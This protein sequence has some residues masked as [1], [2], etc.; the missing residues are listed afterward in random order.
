MT[1][2]V[3]GGRRPSSSCMGIKRREYRED[4]YRKGAL[5][6]D[7]VG[8]EHNRSACCRAAP[9]ARFSAFVTAF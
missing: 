8:V 4:R 1:A 9:E 6:T 2:A 7:T 3:V 5:R